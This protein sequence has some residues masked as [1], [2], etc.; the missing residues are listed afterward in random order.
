[1]FTKFVGDSMI[2]VLKR[3]NSGIQAGCPLVLTAA[4][5][6]LIREW[7]CLHCVCSQVCLRALRPQASGLKASV[8]NV[9]FK[10]AP[11][12]PR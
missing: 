2:Q 9:T 6:R 10:L 7:Q 4:I 3:G 11:E 12:R 5:L 8:A 1:M